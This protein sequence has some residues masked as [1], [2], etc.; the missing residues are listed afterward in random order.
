MTGWLKAWGQPV[1]PVQFTS[2]DVSMGGMH[3]ST[4]M[5]MRTG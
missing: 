1:Q 5:H 3:M 2:M 4:G